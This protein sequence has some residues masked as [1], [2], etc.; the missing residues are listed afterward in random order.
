[1]SIPRIRARMVSAGRYWQCQRSRPQRSAWHRGDSDDARQHIVASYTRVLPRKFLMKRLAVIITAICLVVP[2][3]ASARQ[4]MGGHPKQTVIYGA[5]AISPTNHG[6][7]FS[8]NNRT[9]NDWLVAHCFKAYESTARRNW[10]VEYYSG[11]SNP[12]CNRVASNGLA[13][14]KVERWDSSDG[15]SG[16]YW[17]PVIEFDGA[18][19]PCYVDS[20]THQPRM[21]W[22]AVDDLFRI[23]CPTT[24]F[25]RP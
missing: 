3:V 13:V 22:D 21:P 25:G 9:P 10:A 8:G 16:L 1:M 18:S 17:T 14:L 19:A 12:G 5:F 2:S 23:H 24:S 11:F 7:T 6:D 20:Y 15:T 4:Y